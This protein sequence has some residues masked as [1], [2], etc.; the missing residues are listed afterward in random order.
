MPY[1]FK[2]NAITGQLDLVSDVDTTTGDARY[3]LKPENTVEVLSGATAS[4]GKLY[5]TI[6]DAITYINSQSPAIGNQWVIRSLDSVNTESFTLSNYTHLIGGNA[7]AGLT[8]TIFTGDIVLGDYSILNSVYCTGQ[9]TAG[10]TNASFP[11]ITFGAYLAGTLIIS[12]GTYFQPVS[13]LLQV[14]SDLELNGQM[15][16]LGGTWLSNN[17]NV[18]AGGVFVGYVDMF[19]GTIIDNGGTIVANSYGNYFD[20]SV[21]GYSSD[22][23]GDAIDELTA[24]FTIALGGKVPYT[25]ATANVNLGTWD[26]TTTGQISGGTLTDGSATVIG[27]TFTGTTFT[28][29]TASLTGGALTALTQL[30]MTTVTDIDDILD[31]DTMVSDSATA[32]ATQQ[33]IKAYVDS[34]S[35]WELDGTETKLKT[36]GDVTVG[37]D[38]KVYFN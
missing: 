30:G 5:P 26:L 14:S 19:A 18:N 8:T 33:S 7:Y 17:I 25:G 20:G 35:L 28:D 1:K 6:A 24:A 15:Q 21:S 37:A 2:L 4:A 27:G 10:S 36:A 29:G 16:I 23:V 13:T 3:S 22:T 11:S 31:E 12:A 34:E 9:I 38:Y 32:L